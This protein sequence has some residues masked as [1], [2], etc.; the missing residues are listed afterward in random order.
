MA[1]RLLTLRA[2]REE[3]CSFLVE[4]D[5]D[6]S[7]CVDDNRWMSFL[8]A[9]AKVVHDCPLEVKPEGQRPSNVKPKKKGP[10]SITT[11]VN[12][13]MRDGSIKP[14]EVM[15]RALRVEALPYTGHLSA[16]QPLPMKWAIEYEERETGLL[17]K[18]SLS[19]S[20]KGV[21]S[22]TFGFGSNRTK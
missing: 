11:Q 5:I 10:L 3:L 12:I 7:L 13:E 4:H 1:D 22:R 19:V 2:F 6:P 15:L 14:M 8:A 21:V 17:C 16:D 18:G 20:H 9:Y